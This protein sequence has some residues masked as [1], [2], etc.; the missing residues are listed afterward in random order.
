QN[1]TT[2]VRVAAASQAPVVTAAA[3]IGPVDRPV[4]ETEGVVGDAPSQPAA[5]TS[6][7]PPIS[8]KRNESSVRADAPSRPAARSAKAAATARPAQSPPPLAQTW[9][10]TAAATPPTSAPALP[11]PP[12]ADAAASQ[13]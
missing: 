3:P 9:P 8:L 10:S 7:V 12:A 1:A 5:A 4:Q 11:N 13:A 2:P 6:P